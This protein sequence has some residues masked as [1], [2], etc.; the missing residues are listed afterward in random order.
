MKRVRHHLFVALLL[1]LSVLATAQNQ[2]F[3]LYKGQPGIKKKV[4]QLGATSQAHII[5][6]K[7]KRPYANPIKFRLDEFRK[8][9]QKVGATRSEPLS[10]EKESD[11]ER[12]SV[13]AEA[14]N[15]STLQIWSNF[16]AST[17]DEYPYVVPPDPNGDVSSSQIVTLTNAGVKVFEKRAVTE[18]PLTS[19]KGVS[20]TPA[21]AEVMI[22]L[23]DF[24]APVL[25]TGSYTT[26]PHVRYDRL[27]KRW[28]FVAIEVN[29]SF[30]NNYVFIAVSDGERIVDSSSLVYYRFPSALLPYSSEE[31][32]APFL[33]YPML[34]V[35]KNAVLI[36]GNDFFFDSVY[37]VG[38]AVDKKSLLRG[39]L[40]LYALKLGIID[41]YNGVGGGLV[42][43]QGVQN[44]DGAA[45]KS[46][47][48]GTGLSNNAIELAALT[49]DK[50]GILTGLSQT[51]IPVETF[52]F[53]RDITALGSPMP[54]DPLDTRLLAASIHKN[55]LTG[56]SSLWTAHGIGVNQAG[57]FV[58]A[59]DFVQQARTAA[60]WYEIGAIYTK[61]TL[62][63]LGTVYDGGPSSGR[64]AR[65]FFNPS[66]ASSGQG[67]AVLGG[68]TSVYNGYLNA[69]VAG[70]D[71][72]DAKN[73]MGTPQR[74][75]S[76]RGIYESIF[77]YYIGRWGDYSQTVVDPDD[78]QTIWTFQEYCNA[79]DS[80]GLRATQLKAPPPATPLPLEALSNQRDTT[81]TLEGYS[82]DGSAFFDPGADK[83]GPGYNRLSVKGTGGLLVSALKFISPTQIRFR[84][85]TKNKPAGTYTLVITNPDG[86]IATTEFRIV[87]QALNTVPVTSAMLK[88]EIDA[89][90]ASATVTPNPTPGAFQLQVAAA[91]DWMAR[92]VLMDV[93]G[94]QLSESRHNLGKGQNAIALSLAG[95][96]KG[97]YLAAVYNQQNVLMHIQ[98]VVKQ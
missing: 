29:Q 92:V 43:P 68:T 95:R 27:S 59:G 69:F 86:Q 98:K 35:D 48:A 47:F 15:G 87:A 60:R 57:G 2:K 91:K 85:N 39:E 11:D 33:D 71:H 10:T 40:S 55:K 5:K 94:K 6:E 90:V 22:A 37:F 26:D 53:P 97:T 63:Q 7:I 21:D 14:D 41:F 25:P 80:Y 75:T 52:Q 61:P 19:Y 17:F 76:T 13:L 46:F 83:G 56:K 82:V 64:R 62:S 9:K 42:I 89:H 4:S 32:F 93:S 38:Y 65:T 12:S 49:Y 23:D 81:L 88:K 18:P 54:I 16:L 3:E 31:L 28:F 44:G 50:N 30:E 8:F 72:T 77:G 24:F 70:R 96:G 51:T 45:T 79:D 1:S 67:K 78:D 36:G 34:G 58:A 84:L 74:V 20:R 73:T 66:I